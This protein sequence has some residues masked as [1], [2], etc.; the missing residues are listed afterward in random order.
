[1][2]MDVDIISVLFCR[3]WTSGVRGRGRLTGAH[4][5]EGWEEGVDEMMLVQDHP[6]SHRE[7]LRPLED[8]HH[9]V[10]VGPSGCS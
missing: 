9:M 3:C 8:L 10:R 6:E 4:R 5:A 1:M 7:M 2:Y